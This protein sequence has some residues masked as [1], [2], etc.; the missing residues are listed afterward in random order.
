MCQKGVVNYV[1]QRIWRG[2]DLY[3][4]RAETMEEKNELAH[5]GKKR[6]LRKDDRI[7]NI[8]AERKSKS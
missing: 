5:E 6:F 4:L 8:Q 7:K 2:K 1:L 3:H